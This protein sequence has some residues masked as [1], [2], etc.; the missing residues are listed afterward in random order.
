[1]AESYDA[2][3]PMENTEHMAHN[4]IKTDV[5]K[6]DVMKTPAAKPDS[7]MNTLYMQPDMK[8]DSKLEMNSD[9]KKPM[10][11]MEHQK[12]GQDTE[13][14]TGPAGK[15]GY[16]ENMNGEKMNGEKMNGE[17]MGPVGKI[18]GKIDS[19]SPINAGDVHGSSIVER[20]RNDHDEEEERQHEKNERDRTRKGHGGKGDEEGMQEDEE[21]L[22]DEEIHAEGAAG[23]DEHVLSK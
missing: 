4:G 10:G 23:G 16:G 15:T 19:S 11:Q 5:V 3:T 17:K 1:M 8:S 12:D 6:T 18:V 21:V 14:K 9:I 20:E 2:N 13:G 22:D 7:Y